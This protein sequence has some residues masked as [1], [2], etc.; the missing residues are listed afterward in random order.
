MRFYLRNDFPDRPGRYYICWTRA[1]GRPGRLSCRTTDFATAQAALGQHIVE[2]DQPRDQLA[3]RVTVVSVM[4]RY[5]QHH[6]RKLASKDTVKATLGAVTR[7]LPM[8]TVAELEDR[9]RQDRFIEALRADEIADNTI[10]RRIGVLQ[11]ALYWAKERKEI[12]AVPAK[13]RR[14]NADDGP[15]AK[16]CTPEQLAALF[17]GATLEHHRRFLLLAL[18][19][20]GRPISLVDLD[21]SRV[22]FNT[23][24]IDLV[25]PAVKQTKKRRARVPMP[26]LLAAYLQERK[27]VGPVIQWKGAALE[28]HR[29]M[30]ETICA[31]AGVTVG[32]YSLRA[33]TATWLR[34]K[35]VPEWEVKAMLGH[36]KTTTDRYAHYD[37]E[38]MAEAREAMQELFEGIGAA[39]LA[40]YL[41]APR[42]SPSSPVAVN[43]Q[44]PVAIGDSGGRTWD[45]TTDP[46]H[47]KAAI[48]QVIQ[49]LEAANDD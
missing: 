39:W 38:W 13:L 33:T 45:R 10:D 19:T 28:G 40:P 36:A 34:R 44:M 20:G 21:W 49:T 15:G 9:D 3:A 8:V 6:G 37:P 22:C 35:R 31:A 46:Y 16:P 48:E 4:L 12:G 24:T 27:S 14:P 7:H 18:A 17:A 2:H 1:D 42:Q 29:T 47:V 5:W 11:A 32:A 43:M 26:P 25:N 41:P 23:N 30:M